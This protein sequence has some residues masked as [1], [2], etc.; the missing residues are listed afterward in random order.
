MLLCTTIAIEFPLQAPSPSQI[1]EELPKVLAKVAEKAETIKNKLHVCIENGK[2][3]ATAGCIHAASDILK[4]MDQT[5]DPCDD[6]YKFR[7]LAFGNQ[8]TLT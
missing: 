7:Y 2:V 1:K 8:L 4:R 3:C 5:V 6:F